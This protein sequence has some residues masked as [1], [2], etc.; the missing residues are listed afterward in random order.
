MKSIPLFLNGILETSAITAIEYIGT[1]Q[2]EDNLNGC[3][4][5]YV[6]TTAI[7]IKTNTLFFV[8]KVLIAFPSIW[9]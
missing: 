7:N 3:V 9:Q 6:A 4:P 2:E 8:A 5:K 1:F